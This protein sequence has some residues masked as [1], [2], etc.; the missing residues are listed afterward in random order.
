VKTDKLIWEARARIIWGDSLLSVRNFLISNG[1]SSTVAD[2]KIKEFI[3]EKNTDLKNDGIK[4][5]LSGVILTGASGGVLLWIIF[6]GGLEHL[7]FFAQSITVLICVGLYGAWKLVNGLILLVRAQYKYEFGPDT[8]EPVDD[9]QADD[10]YDAAPEMAAGKP[11]F[12]DVLGISPSSSLKEIKAAY[13]NRIK[14]YHPDKFVDQPPE[15]LQ[16]A[17]E[18]SKTVNLAYEALVKEAKK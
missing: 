14:I 15:A 6:A 13:R 1:V 10:F 5:I 18:M 2:S 9:G 16:W 7:Y 4:E 3:L 8:K 12:Y 17:D 11:S